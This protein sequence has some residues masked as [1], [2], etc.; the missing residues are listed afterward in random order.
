MRIKNKIVSMSV[1]AVFAAIICVF[2]VVTVPVG[3]VP[4]TLSLFA[5]FLT[6]QLLKPRQSVCAVLV[7]ITLGIIGLP[8]FSGFS[9]G[10]QVIAGPTG[11][12]IVCYPIMAAVISLFAAKFGRRLWVNALSGIIALVL[13]YLSGAAWYSTLQGMAFWPVLL[14]FVTQFVPGDV[15]KLA[16]SCMVCAAMNK[17]GACS[18]IDRNI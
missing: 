11:G 1:T 17:V 7:Y 13:C 8:V 14:S 2:A 6:S 3:P 10:I 16:A 5:V 15:I 12:F 4:I 18:Y 9:S